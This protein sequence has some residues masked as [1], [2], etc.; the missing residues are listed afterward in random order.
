VRRE[1]GIME[2]SEANREAGQQGGD[3]G[4]QG[5]NAAK[6]ETAWSF[7]LVFSAIGWVTA[8]FLIVMLVY[9]RLDIFDKDNAANITAALSSLFGIV[10]TLVGA[11]FGIKASADAQGKVQSTQRQATQNVKDTADKALSTADHALSRHTDIVEK[12]ANT[13]GAAGV[14]PTPTQA[15]SSP[16]MLASLIPVAGAA[17]LLILR[18]LRRVQ[19][20]T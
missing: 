5:G 10:G 2:L 13:S 6:P 7:W 1:E 18:Y 17:G 12:A 16:L 14:T 4:Q 19:K 11:Y 15:S 3:A 20:P 9:S 8:A